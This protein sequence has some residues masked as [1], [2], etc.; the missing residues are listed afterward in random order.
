MSSALA[1]QLEA[2][3]KASE[4]RETTLED[5]YTRGAEILTT[6]ISIDNDF[7]SEIDSVISSA[8]EALRNF[9]RDILFKTTT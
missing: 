9:L 6:D 1:T 5:L 7:A 2:L 4:S 3:E 8:D